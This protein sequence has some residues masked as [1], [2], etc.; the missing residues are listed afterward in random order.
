MAAER[1]PQRADLGERQARAAALLGNQRI[2]KARC[3]KAV[4]QCIGAATRL[5]RAHRRGRRQAFQHPFERQEKFVHHR[6]PIPRAMMPRNISR[7]PPRSE[8]L[9][10]TWVT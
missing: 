6:S 7:V 5:D 8:K 4:P 9:G 3:G 10:A 2:E 1:L